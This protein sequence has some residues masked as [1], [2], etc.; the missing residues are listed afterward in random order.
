MDDGTDE[1][2]WR[3]GR[4]IEAIEAEARH[5]YLSLGDP[6][7]N[8]W[9]EAPKLAVAT[10]RASLAEQVREAALPMRDTGYH[11]ELRKGWAQA[12]AVFLALIEEKP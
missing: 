6:R 5:G 10:Y 9:V 1:Y 3:M 4:V 11:P 8:E 7:I 2:V 12:E